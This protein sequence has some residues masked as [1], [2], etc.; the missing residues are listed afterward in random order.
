MKNK[1]LYSIH[2]AKEYV[3]EPTF[4]S[5]NRKH[6]K[7]EKRTV[8]IGRWSREHHQIE[9]KKRKE[10]NEQGHDIPHY[11]PVNLT[12]EDLTVEETVNFVKLYPENLKIEFKPGVNLIVGGNGCGKST[13][14][15]IINQ[16]ITGQEDYLKKIGIEIKSENLTKDNFFGWDFEKDNPQ[17][18]K[19]MRP[20]PNS[21][22]FIGQTLFLMSCNEE[23]HGE[24]TR[25]VLN[26]FMCAKNSL[27]IFD[28]PETALSLKAQYKYWSKIKK[29]S[30]NNQVIL[31]SHSKIFMEEQKEV[32]DMESKQWMNVEEYF[33]S[34]KG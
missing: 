34:I 3:L 22:D 17:S 19:K 2:F 6:E 23:S 24:T 9:D 10:L 33:K 16:F 13:L 27:L 1:F 25:G 29:I 30:K 4:T 28:E 14:L 15:N 20:D 12:E 5:P 21:S 26:S 32:F 8:V 11:H 18:N 31:I 7:V